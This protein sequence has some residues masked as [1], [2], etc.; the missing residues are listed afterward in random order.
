MARLCLLLTLIASAAAA[1]SLDV[2]FSKDST[3]YTIAVGGKTWFNS[4]PTFLDAFST[5]DGTL[6]LVSA[7]TGKAAARQ[8]A[9]GDG[10]VVTQTWLAG[11]VHYVTATEVFPSNFHDQG[12]LG[13]VIFTQSFPDGLGAPTQ[14]YDR[15][16]LSGSCRCT[17]L[18]KGRKGR[19]WSRNGVQRGARI[20]RVVGGRSHPLGLPKTVLP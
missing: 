13:T 9:I 1:P 12:H 4:G 18:W 15:G 5:A 17:G 2:V 7:T 8:P 20:E 19:V 3:S 14:R 6:K 16:T 10:T 11:K